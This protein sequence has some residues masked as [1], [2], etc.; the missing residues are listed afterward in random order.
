[1]YFLFFSSGKKKGVV[2]YI[3]RESKLIGD[4]FGRINGI[5]NVSV[6]LESFSR[7][8]PFLFSSFLSL[9]YIYIFFFFGKFLMN[10]HIIHIQKDMPNAQPSQPTTS[11][12]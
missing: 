10:D 9:Y 6:D 1:M 11:C 2:W 8:V 4:R 7:Y 3:E 5:E 12:Y